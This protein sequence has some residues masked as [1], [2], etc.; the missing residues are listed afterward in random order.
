MYEFGFCYGQG[1]QT[2]EES[3]APVYVLLFKFE[4]VVVIAEDKQNHVEI[5][6]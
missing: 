6:E 3:F 5:C 1:Q 4:A 2:S